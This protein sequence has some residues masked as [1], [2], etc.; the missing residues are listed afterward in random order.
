MNWRNDMNNRRAIVALLAT[1]AVLLALNLVKGEG[2]AEAGVQGA[3]ELDVQPG[4]GEPYIVKW[5]SSGSTAYMRVWTDGQIDYTT[6]LDRRSCD[7]VFQAVLFGPVD[8]PFPVVDANKNGDGIIVEYEDG[9]VDHLD[10]DNRD[11]PCTIAGSGSDPFCLG[12][13]DRNGATNFDDLLFVLR[14]WGVCEG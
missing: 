4:G 2:R 11:V 10:F 8:H 6:R 5:L 14:D 13:I 1:I 12:D 3:V 9:R 7:W